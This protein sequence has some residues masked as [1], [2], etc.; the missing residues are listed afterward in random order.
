MQSLKKIH[1]WAQMQDP[2]FLHY[3]I[4]YQSFS[5]N[6]NLYYPRLRLSKTNEDSAISAKAI[7]D[8]GFFPDFRTSLI[9]FAIS[10]LP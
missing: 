8:T 6:Q 9:S 3:T 2:L 10:F 5:I 1:V 7:F 4:F